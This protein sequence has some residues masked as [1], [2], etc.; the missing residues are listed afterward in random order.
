MTMDANEVTALQSEFY[1]L[2]SEVSKL[3]PRVDTVVVSDEQDAIKAKMAILQKRQ[4]ELIAMF[5]EYTDAELW[6]AS[7]KLEK[8]YI[9]ALAELE[10]V[11]QHLLY[12]GCQQIAAINAKRI[13]LHRELKR[14]ARI[15]GREKPHFP[16]HPGVRANEIC[17]PSKIQNAY[18]GFGDPV[19]Q[20]RGM[21][22]SYGGLS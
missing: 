17:D 16:M 18:L 8:V 15:S 19:T 4:F 3:A 5:G 11:P 2:Q 20:G 12:S 6:P 22:T 1:Q 10:N 7:N 14:C 13:T 9:A 21:R